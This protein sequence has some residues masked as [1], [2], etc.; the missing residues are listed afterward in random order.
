MREKNRVTI[1]HISIGSAFKV[2]VALYALLFAIFG[3]IG[4]IFYGLFIS[5][6]GAA[7]SQGTNELLG[8]LGGGFIGGLFAYAFGIFFYGFM[9]GIFTAISALLY[10]IVAGFVGGLEVDLE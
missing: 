1:G 3:L 6:A 9:G 7:A 5:M 8:I 10:N 2:G 4:L